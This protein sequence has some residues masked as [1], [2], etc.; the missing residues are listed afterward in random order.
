MSNRLFVT[1]HKGLVE[2]GRSPS[3]GRWEIVRTSFLGDNVTMVLPDKRD[4]SI[5]AALGLGHFGCKLRRST[6]G[7]ET[8]D[9]CAVPEYPSQTK[10]EAGE[11]VVAPGKTS[12]A[13][14]YLFAL[15]AADPNQPGTLWCGTVPGGLFRSHDFGKSWTLIRSLWDLPE[16][17]QW[18]GG[19]MDRPGIH[20][21]CVDPRDARHVT[22]GVSCGGVWD[23][24][25]GG[26]TWQNLSKGMWAAYMPPEQKDNPNVQDVHRL[27]QCAAEPDRLW[28]QHHNGMFC[29]HDGC[30]L[31]HDLGSVKPSNFGFAVAVH[32]RDGNTAWFVP[33]VKDECRVPVDGNLV[34]TRTRDGGKSFDILSKGLPQGNAFDVVYRHG[35]DIDE[36]GDRLAFGSTTGSLWVTE[37]QGDDWQCVS[38]HLAPI[39]CVR[40]E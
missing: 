6:N 14:D 21:I 24:R 4:G 2:V 26:E 13:L 19:G 22:V 29:T 38:E 8:W 3:S 28:V 27:V 15:E 31:W 10:E 16:R 18:F 9:E 34:V 33:G 1:T 36:T 25:D 5:Y 12:P 37:N 7:G 11:G 17:K 20:S 30:A 39:R 40:F 32:P 35:L 23:T